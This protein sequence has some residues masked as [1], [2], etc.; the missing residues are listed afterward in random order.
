MYL[1]CIKKIFLA[2]FLFAIIEKYHNNTTEN[3]SQIDKYNYV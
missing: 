2:F 1:P 3:S